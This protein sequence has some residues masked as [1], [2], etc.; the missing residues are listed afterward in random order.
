MSDFYEVLGS[1]LNLQPPSIFQLQPISVGHGNR[2]RKVEKN[3]VPLIC[4]Q[5]KAA[6]MARVEV[7]SERACRLLRRP[8][9]GGSMNRSAMSRITVNGSV[10]R[11]HSHTQYMK[12]R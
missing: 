5:T 8:I 4:R 7:E 3:I 9:P 12:Y 1:S 6:A 11:S 2:L 10:V